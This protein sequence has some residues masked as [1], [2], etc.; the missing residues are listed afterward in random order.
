MFKRLIQRLVGRSDQRELLHAVTANSPPPAG[1]PPLAKV[2]VEPTTRCN[3]RCRTCMRGAWDEPGDQMSAATFAA[4]VQGLAEVK[5]LTS[6][7][8]WGIGEPL[9]HPDLPQM[10]RQVKQLGARTEVVTNAL[11]L[12]P[13]LAAQLVAA[14]LDRL[15]VSLDG[16]TAEAHASVRHGADLHVME[17]NLAAL[18]QA[19]RDHGVQTPQIGVEYVLTRSNLAQLADLPA[20]ARRLGA[21]FIFVSNVLP[22]TEEYR[23]EILYWLAAGDPY[24]AARFDGPTLATMPRVD[25]RPDVLEHL[26]AVGSPALDAGL[27]TTRPLTDGIC[28]FVVEGAA[29]VCWDGSVSPCVPLMHSHRCF[30]VGRPKSIR[31]HV[32]GNVNSQPLGRIYQAEDYRQF[33]KRVLDFTFSPC[34]ACGG[35]DLVDANEEDCF[36]N[37]H[38]TCGDCLWARGVIICP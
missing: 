9:L 27:L 11:L 26:W 20:L 33:R 35:C 14:G 36:G 28:P 21:G 3:L 7:A 34:V 29:A 37:P 32:V 18:R 2:Y 10:I 5:T 24:S 13:P 30:V 22:Y 1:D 25:A 6:V 19:R 4:L 23:D 31:R 8:F 17:R 38:P 12:E 16:T 15:V